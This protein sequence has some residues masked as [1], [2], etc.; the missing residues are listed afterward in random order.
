MI[1]S[2]KSLSS[3]LLFRYRSLLYRQTMN[4]ILIS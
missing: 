2:R 4:M 1:S 3:L